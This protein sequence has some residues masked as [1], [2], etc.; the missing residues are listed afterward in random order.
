MARRRQTKRR[1]RRGSFGFLYKLLSVLVICTAILA[2]M[3][4]FFRVGSIVVTGQKRYTAEEIQAASGVDLGSNMYL[5]NKFDVVR[6]ITGELPYIEDIR[7]NRKLPDT[8]LIEVRESGRPFAL[9]QDGSAW[10]VSAGGKLVDQIPE[11]EAGQYG[12]I[13]GCQ[14]LA[15]SVGTPLALATE[16]AAQQSSLLDLLAALDSA[17]LTE[18]VDAIRLD[19]L[20]DLKMDYIG[21][22]TVRMAYGADY[23]FE[24]KKLT[25]TLEDEKIQSNMTGTIDLRLKSEDVFIIPGER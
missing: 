4:L 15:P 6:A 24:L 10:L 5:L 2:A 18:N 9:V 7:I 12:R 14:L 13:T 8:L 19:D 17:G 11:R 20:S 23:G 3:T 16:Y 21:R 1:R 22:F 25:L